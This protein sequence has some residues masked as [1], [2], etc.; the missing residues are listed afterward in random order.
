VPAS[1]PVA[2]AAVNGLRVEGTA[3]FTSYCRTE[4]SALLADAAG[5]LRDEW[6]SIA[7][8]LVV[9]LGAVGLLTVS[10]LALPARYQ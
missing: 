2:S 1:L 5:R 7:A 4:R 10:G 9:C 8:S 3:A 6:K